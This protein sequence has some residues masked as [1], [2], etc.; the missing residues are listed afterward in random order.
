MK[1][2]T[3][4]CEGPTEQGFC[5]QVLRPHLFPTCDGILHTILIAHAKHHGKV[6]RGGVPAHYETMRRDITNELKGRKHETD[7]FTTLIDLYGLPEDFP[8]KDQNVRNPDNPTPYVESLEVAFG[9]DI[10]DRRFIPH[11]QLHEYETMLF[12]DPEAFQ[13]AF[14][15]CD[16]A[17][18]QLKAIA[19]SCA[20][21]EQIDDGATTAPSKRI[22]RLVPAYEGRKSSAGPDIAE[23]TGLPTIR[24]K[25]HHFDRWL[26]RLE[27]LWK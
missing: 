3:V 19:K 23:Y 17:I 25:C 13:V 10:G 18:E 15:D 1:R 12:A 21:I 11:L 24:A 27:E 4:F 9:D 20:S 6:T 16:K 2:L 22:I 14:D 5:N 26:T 8:G 7:F